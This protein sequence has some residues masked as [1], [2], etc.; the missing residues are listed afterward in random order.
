MNL[1]TINLPDIKQE[2]LPYAYALMAIGALVLVKKP[3]TLISVI[4]AYYLWQN[5]LEKGKAALNKY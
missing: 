2:H 4:S 3:T 1:P 5:T